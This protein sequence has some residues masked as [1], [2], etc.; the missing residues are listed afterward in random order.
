MIEVQ[1]GP[2]SP[3]SP[4]GIGDPLSFGRA[5]GVKAVHGCNEGVGL[6]V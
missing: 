5:E 2:S 4:A 3:L 1:A 6:A